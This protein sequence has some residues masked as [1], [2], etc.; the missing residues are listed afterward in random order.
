MEPT[1]HTL[2]LPAE[3]IST[4]K[5]T[6]AQK[7]HDR[8]SLALGLIMLEATSNR[9]A[10]IERANEIGELLN[11]RFGGLDILTLA[12]LYNIAITHAPETASDEKLA[13]IHKAANAVR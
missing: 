1:D 3:A 6:D 8:T 4:G 12:A 5:T 7:A 13:A 2:E 11:E 9:E 10:L